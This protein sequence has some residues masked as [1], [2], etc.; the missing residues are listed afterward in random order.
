M[1]TATRPGRDGKSYPYPMPHGAS[2]DRAEAIRAEHFLR[3]VM[4]FHY[5]EI[6]GELLSQYGIR[7][8]IGSVHRDIREFTCEACRDDVPAGAH[9]TEA[10]SGAW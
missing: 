9:V 1:A 3:C 10:A 7:R 2:P 6:P 4:H 5:E 8:S